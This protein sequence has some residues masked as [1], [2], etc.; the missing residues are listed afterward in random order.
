MKKRLEIKIN[1]IGDY[2]REIVFSYKL[3][4]KQKEFKINSYTSGFCYLKE[5][6]LSE[7]KSCSFMS[8][9]SFTLK[10]FEKINFLLKQD[11]I[12]VNSTEISGKETTTIIPL[13]EQIA[14]LEIEF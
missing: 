5:D 9:L 10:D 1:L 12:V 14:F 13:T 8:F 11:S 6:V 4:K 2:C 3:G 7:I